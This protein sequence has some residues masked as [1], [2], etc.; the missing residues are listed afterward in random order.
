M[1]FR[2]IPEYEYE[3]SADGRVRPLG[4]GDFLKAIISK[5]GYLKVLIPGSA[6]RKAVHRLILEAWVGPCPDNMRTHFKDGNNKN[7]HVT[8]LCWMD[9]KE[10]AII[11]TDARLPARIAVA[12]ADAVASSAVVAEQHRARSIEAIE[13]GESIV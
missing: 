11:E 4:G 1:E 5:K 10:V 6:R 2:K 9:L 7:I 3:I 8:N 12:L 13:A